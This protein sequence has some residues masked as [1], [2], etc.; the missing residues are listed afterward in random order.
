MTDL[1]L[2]LDNFMLYCSS[3]NLSRKTLARYKQ[4]LKLF[5][6]YL[7]ESKASSTIPK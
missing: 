6:M 7:K 5:T 1:E 3:N 2:L 4:T